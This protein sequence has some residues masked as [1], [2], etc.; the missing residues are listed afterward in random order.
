LGFSAAIIFGSGIA[1]SLLGTPPSSGL[2]I[3]IVFGAALAGRLGRRSRS[4]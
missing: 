4:A 1:F 2:L 3:V